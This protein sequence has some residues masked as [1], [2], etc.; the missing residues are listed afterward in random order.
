[1]RVRIAITSGMTLLMLLVPSAAAATNRF[2]FEDVIEHQYS[3]GVVETTHVYGTEADHFRPDGSLDFVVIRF[4]YEGSFVDPASGQTIAQ[5]AR[6]NVTI[7]DTIA[8]R[9]QGIFLRLNGEGVVLHDVGRLVFDPGDLSTFTASAKVLPF[10]D[11]DLDGRID[12]AVCSM[13][14]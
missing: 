14:N 10:D 6:Q 8:S 11:P 1:M 5:K 12:A 7:D 4:R 3:C 13:F 2:T 9:G